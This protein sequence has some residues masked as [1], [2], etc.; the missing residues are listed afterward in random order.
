[1]E[2]DRGHPARFTSAGV[3]AA[4][5]AAMVAFAAN[6]VLCRLALGHATIDAPSF[7]TVRL[8]SGALTLLALAS[9]LHRGREIA[10][11][12]GWPAAGALFGYAIAF[13]FAY[14]SLSAGTGALILFGAVQL[15]MILAALRAGERPGALQWLGFACAVV[16]LVYLVAPGVTAPSPLGALLMAFAGACWGV[17]SLLGRGSANPMLD[18]TANFLRA[19]PLAVVASAIAFAHMHVSSTGLLLATASGA[20]SSGLGYVIWYAALRGLTATR[21]AIVQLVVP[22]L[23][24]LGGV[25]FLG[26][27]FTARLAIA[28]VLILGGVALAIAA[29]RT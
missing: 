4:T 10:P 1:M 29:R 9:T 15:T 22:L 19:A 17:Y 3:A 25:I 18:T 14:L 11:R 2:S 12:G 13:S 6:S 26:E 28:G 5:A 27:E 8:V 7:T 24:A 23:A 20:V 21:A 16:G